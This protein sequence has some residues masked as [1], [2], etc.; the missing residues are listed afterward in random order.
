LKLII[1][2]DEANFTLLSQG[3]SE[4]ALKALEDKLNRIERDKLNRIERRDE[5][6]QQVNLTPTP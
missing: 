6:Q 1:Q 4:L 3:P 5:M 2:S